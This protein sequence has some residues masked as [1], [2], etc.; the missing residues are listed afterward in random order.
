MFK[1]YC[2]AL[3]DSFYNPRV[4]RD[5]ITRW[6]GFGGVYLTLLAAIIA[7]VVSVHFMVG[8]HQFETREL[9]GLLA[10]VPE[11][12]IKHGVISVHEGTKEPVVIKPADKDITITID[13][14]KS[15]SELRDTK[16]QIG[17]GKDFVFVQAGQDYQVSY[18]ESLR[19]QN[20]RVNGTILR[21]MWDDV[22]PLVRIIA[23]P[24]LWLG[25]FMDLIVKG[26]MVALFSYAV[27]AFMPEEYIFITRMRLAALALTPAS[28]V[29]I[30]LY[31]IMGHKT[32]PWF[33]LLLA[34]L[35]IYVMITL[36][37]RLPAD[38]VDITA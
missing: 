18:L 16:T 23:P 38:N 12:H 33:A 30:G 2:R 37:R 3:I 25:Q 19:D 29:S 11:M 5:A 4:Y 10:Q 9:P 26:L 13:T 1:T 14:Q 27:T 31:L 35:Y 28:L 34:T 21:Q 20:V 17:I 36:I 6:Q 32:A 22:M 7:L 8:L 15:E 24:V